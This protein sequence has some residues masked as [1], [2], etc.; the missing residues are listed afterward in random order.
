MDVGRV[1]GFPDVSDN[2]PAPDA[3]TTKKAATAMP[4]TTFRPVGLA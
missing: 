3:A 4:M 1:A 2:L